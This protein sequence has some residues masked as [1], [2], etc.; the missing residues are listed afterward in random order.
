MA[1]S[2]LFPK[3]AE[4]LRLRPLWAIKGLPGWRC[5]TFADPPSFPYDFEHL[6]FV[7]KIAYYPSFFKPYGN[8][9]R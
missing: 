2:P 9:T 8:T 4:R 5:C 3:V 7:K 1:C 6:D